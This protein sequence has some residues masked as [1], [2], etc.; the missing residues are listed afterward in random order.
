MSWDDVTKPVKCNDKCGWKNV[1]SEI[2]NLLNDHEYEFAWRFLHDLER[3]IKEHEHVTDRQKQAVSNVITGINR[4]DNDLD[5]WDFM[6]GGD[7]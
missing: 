4:P 2:N 5:A 7:E 1:L 6:D 3:W